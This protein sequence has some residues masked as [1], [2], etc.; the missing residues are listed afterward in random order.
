MDI[1]RT[2]HRIEP[3]TNTRT[4]PEPVH[5]KV[6]TGSNPG[7][8]HPTHTHLHRFCCPFHRD[9]LMT[10]IFQKVGVVDTPPTCATKLVDCRSS[11][12]FSPSGDTHIDAPAIY[13][14]QYDKIYSKRM[15]G[16]GL[17]VPVEVG[18]DGPVDNMVLYH[19]TGSTGLKGIITTT[20]SI[21]EGPR[22]RYRKDTN[23]LDGRLVG[24]GVYSS[25]M[26]TV[27]TKY[28]D[29]IRFKTCTGTKTYKC[30]CKCR[31]RNLRF[32]MKETRYCVSDTLQAY[33]IL[34]LDVSKPISKK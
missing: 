29:P 27:A 6:R 31:G 33:Q 2:F 23:V 12:L 7:D 15:S 20:G 25:P 5:K 14:S 30:V 1:K 10:R 24:K 3:R 21:L 32:P 18:C 4:A 19:G 28:S 13:A 26:L 22:Q 9:Q 16:I 11:A 8:S 34:L 17:T